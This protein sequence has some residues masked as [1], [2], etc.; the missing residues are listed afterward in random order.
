MNNLPP[1]VEEGNKEY[2][3]KLCNLSKYRCIQLQSQMKWRIKEGNGIAIY[4]IG[5]ED[6]GSI[7][8]ISSEER[9]E[10]IKNIKKIAKNI[11]AFVDSIDFKNNYLEITIKNNFKPIDFYEKRIVFLGESGVGK[12][13]LIS[14]L[15][16]GTI[17]DGNGLARLALFNHKHEMFTGTTS[18]ISLEDFDIH[19]KNTKLSK[20]KNYKIV[21]I[22]LPGN[23]KYKK[24]KYYGLQSLDPELIIYVI[25]NTVTEEKIKE[26]IKIAN[27]LKVPILLVI[28]KIDLY[29]STDYQFDFNEY[30]HITTSCVNKININILKEKFLDDTLQLTEINSD[31]ET[32]SLLSQLLLEDDIIFQINDIYQI[33]DIGVILSGIQIAG[34]I[35]FKKKLKLG[36]ININGKLKYIDV[37][38]TS[39]HISKI[40]AETLHSDHLATLVI[41]FKDPNLEILIPKLQKGLYLSNYDL[42]LVNE[43]NCSLTLTHHKKCLK[44]GN[45]IHI[46]SRNH[47]LEGKIIFIESNK[48]ININETKKCKIKLSK[49]CY[50][51]EKDK[52]IFDNG[53]AKG[54]GTINLH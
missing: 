30:N 18:S 29:D 42:P 48:V 34:E 27:F 2:K 47:I 40:P 9:K 8:N 26:N 45:Q 11:G 32:S 15:S 4:L 39:I 10:S 25:D 7:S 44:I 16:K 43:F 36:P 14:V 37:L 35:K 33:N 51:R 23:E 24:T 38:V 3:R 19:P 41:N 28:N 17:D 1:E 20:C 5:V 50:I 52:F 49:F 31:E 53:I 13:T 21:L 46:F 12:S 6:D 22:D 54:F